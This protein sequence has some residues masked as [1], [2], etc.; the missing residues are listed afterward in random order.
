[1]KLYRFFVFLALVTLT[2]CS[3]ILVNTTNRDGIA[4]DPTERTAGAIVEDLSLIH[5]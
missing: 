1:M 5:I 4:E 2:S 3:T